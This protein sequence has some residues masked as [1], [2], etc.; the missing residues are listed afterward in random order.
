MHYVYHPEHD[1]KV[2][3]TQEYYTLLENGW[4]DTPAKFPSNNP[5]EEVKEIKE[6]ELTELTGLASDVP[7]PRGRPKKEP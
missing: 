5:V 6:E 4:Y 2:V 3:D 1:A 7:K